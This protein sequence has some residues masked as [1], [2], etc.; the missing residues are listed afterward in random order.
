MSYPALQPVTREQFF[1]AVGNL[2]VHPRIVSDWPY[3]SEWR[4]QDNSR[5]IVGA[6]QERPERPECPN[7]LTETAYYLAP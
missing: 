3:R 7:G 1:A 4:L 5:K 2:D 6:S